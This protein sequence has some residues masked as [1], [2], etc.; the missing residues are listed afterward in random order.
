[1]TQ[2]T[3]EAAIDIMTKLIITGPDD[4]D[5]TKPSVEDQS[6]SNNEIKE[7]KMD[8][9]AVNTI[10]NNNGNKSEKE[11]AEKLEAFDYNLIAIN[12]VQ[13]QIEYHLSNDNLALDNFLLAKMHQ[14]PEYW[15]S[16][17]VIANLTKIKEITED[18]NIILAAI[19]NSE[20]LILNENETKIKR[21]DYIPP[22]PKHHKNM[23]RTVFVYGLS[24]TDD[25]QEITKL[26][27]DHGNLRAIVFDNGSKF[28]LDPENITESDLEEIDRNVAVQIMTKKLG[29]RAVRSNS[30]AYGDILSPS[31]SHAWLDME[32][33]RVSTELDINKLESP[34][35]GSLNIPDSAKAPSSPVFVHPIP[36]PNGDPLDFSHLRTCFV[37]FQSQSQANNFIKSRA[38]MNDGI[39]ALHQY[40]YI[41]YQKRASMNHARGISPLMSPASIGLTLNSPTYSI[42]GSTRNKHH[43]QQKR[44]SAESAKSAESAESAFQFDQYQQPPLLQQQYQSM[45]FVEDAARGAMEYYLANFTAGTPMLIVPAN[46]ADVM[47]QTFTNRLNTAPHSQQYRNK[48]NNRNLKDWYR[49]SHSNNHNQ[50]NSWKGDNNYRNSRHSYKNKKNSHYN[51][52][53]HQ[54]WSHG[55]QRNSND[56]HNGRFDFEVNHNYKMRGS[57]NSYNNRHYGGSQTMKYR[58]MRKSWRN[59]ANHNHNES[60]R[61]P[62]SPSPNYFRTGK[63]GN[64]AIKVET[65]VP[66]YVLKHQSPAITPN[67]S[68]ISAPNDQQQRASL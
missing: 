48:R 41:K 2:I 7:K 25:Q 9:L 20:V 18:I 10:D 43:N 63:N 14:D 33:K 57:R 62:P 24:E 23:R 59:T 1:M 46:V 26:C 27:K 11:E 47:A 65:N 42:L 37:I 61:F 17:K 39:R 58:D 31:Q 19:R 68:C 3:H 28:I 40:E 54:T 12:M 4:E 45:N 51:Y 56:Y 44:D 49:N 50:R 64:G 6:D 66:R 55:Q 30:A 8:N 53:G 22:K 52:N 35:M 60:G 21:K 32:Q 38:K 29:P 34:S 36:N 13:F 5:N 15:V 16:L 67:I